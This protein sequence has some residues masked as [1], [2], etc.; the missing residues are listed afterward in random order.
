M[1]VVG[2][3]AGTSSLHPD[4]MNRQTDEIEITATTIDDF[5]LIHK[6]DQIHLLK[7]DT[8]GHD[9]EVLLGAEKVL[10]DGAVLICQFEYNHRW[11]FSR[12]YLKDVFDFTEGMPYI[13]GKVTPYGIEVYESWYPELD[14]FFEG[15]YVLINKTCI[16]WFSKLSVISFNG[17]ISVIIKK[18]G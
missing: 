6:I 2:G 12:H 18:I 5:C 4:S 9:M 14:R 16:G 7:V 1:F 13:L 10:R 17:S 15:N 3:R 8:E 11:I